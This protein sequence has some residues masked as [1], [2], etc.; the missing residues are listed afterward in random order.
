[1]G[2][3]NG[4]DDDNDH[5][6]VWRS[7]F[8][9]GA[10]HEATPR[11]R[12]RAAGGPW[13]RSGVGAVPRYPAGFERTGEALRHPLRRPLGHVGGDALGVA[14]ATHLLSRDEARRIVNIAK[15][16]ELLRPI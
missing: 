4:Q 8:V 13:M 12:L 1:M 9:I 3:L 7:F 2:Q 11:W 10:R 16:P 15:L 6:C 14:R 5:P